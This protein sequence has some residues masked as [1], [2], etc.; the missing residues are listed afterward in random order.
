[1]KPRS[2]SSSAGLDYHS[3]IDSVNAG[4][5]L[6]GR[7]FRVQDANLAQGAFFKKDPKSF[8]GRFCYEAF[9]KRR[10][11]CHHCP[12]KRAMATGRT[13]EATTTGV[14]DDGSRFPVLIRAFPVKGPDGKASAFI[15]IVEDLSPRLR[16]KEEV[17]LKN[18]LLRAQLEASPDGILVVDPKGRMLSFNRRFVE[19]WGIPDRVAQSRSDTAALEAVLSKLADPKS[20]LRRV[21]QLYKDPGLCSREEVALKDG[22]TFDRHSAPVTGTGGFY[23]GRVWFFRDITPRK[24]AEQSL[25]ENESLYHALFDQAGE[26]IAL[27]SSD[28]KELHLSPSFARMHGY[29]DP[30]EMAGVSLASIDTPETRRLAAGRLKRMLAGESLTFEVEHYRKDG[31]AFPLSVTCDVIDI[32][33]RKFFLG[34]HKDITQRKKSEAETSLL[35]TVSQVFSDGQSVEQ[36]CAGIAAIV[37]RKLGVDGC[38]IFEPADNGKSVRVLSIAAPGRVPEPGTILPAAKTFSGRVLAEGKPIFVRDYREEARSRRGVSHR[39]G[40]RSGLCVPVMDGPSAILSVSVATARVREDLPK[41]APILTAVGSS[42]ASAIKRRNA[43]AALRE[44]E[45]KFRAAFENAKDAMLWADPA[46]GLILNCN[47]AAEKLFGRPRSRLI[48]LHQTKLHPR[49]PADHYRNY[50][51]N[52]ARAGAAQDDFAEISTA[53]GKKVPVSISAQRFRI[54]GR[55][56]LQGIFR[57]ISERQKVMDALSASR[58]LYKALAEGIPDFVF[59][60]DAKGRVLYSNRGMPGMPDPVGKGQFD[61]FPPESAKQHLRVL[62][63]VVRA[64]KPSL[65]EERVDWFGRSVILENRLIPLKGADG[66]V[67]QLLGLSRDVT[68]RR[69]T[70]EAL[71]ESEERAST[72]L[73]NVQDGIW[74]ADLSG[75]YD[76]LN[77]ALERIYGLT[78]AEMEANPDFWIDAAHPEDRGKLRASD[79]AL[80]RDGRA[81]CEHRCIRSDGKV[82]WLYDRKT[83][84]R[85]ARGKPFKMIGV[86]SDITERRE[87]EESLKASEERF[88]TLIE[89]SGVAIGVVREGRLILANRAFARMHGYGSPEGLA[90]RD[91]FAFVAPKVRPEI[92]RLYRARMAGKPVPNGYESLALRQDGTTFPVFK[93]MNTIRLPDGDAVVGYFTDISERKRTEAEVRRLRAAVAASQ[94][95]ERRRLSRELHDGVGQI[96]S[97][98]KF[99]LQALPRDMAASPGD[100]KR[101]VLKAAGRIDQ[102]I[103]E[104]RRVSQNLM[105]SELEDLGLQPALMA[106]CRGFRERSGVTTGLRF[107]GIPGRLSENVSM[108]LYRVAQEALTNVERHARAGSVDLLLRR[109][110]K[111]IEM[112]VAD[113]GKGCAPGRRRRKAGDGGL[114]LGNISERVGALGGS[115]RFDSKPG[116][117]TRLS[118][119]VPMGSG[120]SKPS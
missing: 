111:S 13:C 47:K 29:E 2:Y 55:E 73:A 33:G 91:A 15:E 43:T 32:R 17:G 1:M 61:L 90:G 3:L 88:K 45:E 49:T 79:K 99:S 60:L 20:F 70:E 54:G 40:I 35:L 52:H 82:R 59:L 103:A 87:M 4:I 102:A 5:A 42:I 104:I 11:V 78:R 18:A 98:V 118:V 14:R 8:I 19:M 108:A 95:T 93:Q 23:Y 85:D 112:A 119:S 92:R 56:V 58:Q 28:G 77:P 68:E 38:A 101:L 48:G 110:G 53:S 34:F 115:M 117:G 109:R 22:R 65:R 67:E 94:E 84:I 51:K 62:R 105:P 27:M 37:A 21:R 100:A 66:R 46:T 6:I 24:R 89:A 25:K 74:S 12:G 96:L 36:A 39:A 83:I 63:R 26:G 10:G 76:Y 7:D 16:T 9:E 69:R 64:G 86:L 72:I 81:I 116:K 97:G 57:D 120:G 106:L 107:H 114:G 113:D 80:H 44:S 75:R 31:S 50:F 41:L 71:R 30:K